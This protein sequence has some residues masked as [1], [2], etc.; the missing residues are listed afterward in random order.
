MSAAPNPRAQ[1][2]QLYH[3]YLLRQEY[4]AAPAHARQNDASSRVEPYEAVSDWVQCQ[5][6]YFNEIDRAAEHLFK[7]I[8]LNR[9]R[10]Y[11]LSH[12]AM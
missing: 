5:H 1:S 11:C 12:A 8:R 9:S 10:R 6:D 2:V 3:T 7:M 4:A